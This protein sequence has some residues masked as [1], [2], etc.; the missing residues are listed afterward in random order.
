MIGFVDS[1]Q[2][3][4]NVYCVVVHPTEGIIAMLNLVTNKVD[5]VSSLSPE[6]KEYALK[7]ISSRY[8][9]FSYDKQS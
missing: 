2:D 4:A 9:E 5:L 7:E 1:Q 6:L 3:V 8:S